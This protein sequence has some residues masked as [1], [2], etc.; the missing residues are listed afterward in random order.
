MNGG[1]LALIFALL[2]TGSIAA[3]TAPAQTAA[4]RTMARVGLALVIGNSKYVQSELP[5]VDE[6]RRAMGRALTSL[7]F[8]VRE[9]ENLR[10]PL[11][12]EEELRTFLKD[13]DAAPEDTLVVY[14]S[15]HGLQIEGRAY[16]L[17]T[18]FTGAGDLG[19]ALR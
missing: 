19:A 7:G 5:S 18:G 6:D 2:E 12:F 3:Y 4:P 11:D 17:G 13:E 15:G 8:K 16:V 9:A 10:R 1:V 14:F